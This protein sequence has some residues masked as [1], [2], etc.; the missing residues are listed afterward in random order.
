MRSRLVAVMTVSLIAAAAWAGQAQGAAPFKHANTPEN[1]KA[2][3]QL[4]ARKIHVDKAPK[5]GIALFRA[6]IPD[7]TRMRK[8][9]KDD[10]TPLAAKTVLRSLMEFA[11][12]P[13]ETIAALSRPEQTMVIVSGA[14]TEEIKAYAN[15]SLAFRKFPGGA[16]N[17]AEQILRS[18][19][20]FYEVEYV[21]PGKEA[22]IKY[23]LFYWDGQQ[24]SMLGP[25]WRGLAG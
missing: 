14:T 19:V 2:L 4:I 11:S 25:A 20:T 21:E 10:V 7:E 17:A 13:D 23:H 15:G 8:A 12:A 3:M 6:M 16:K 1:L 18:G 24:W 22:G 5:E 9:L